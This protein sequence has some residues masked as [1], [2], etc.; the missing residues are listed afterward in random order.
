MTFGRWHRGS[1]SISSDPKDTDLQIVIDFLASSY[2][3]KHLPRAKIVQSFDNCLVY[4]LLDHDIDRQVGFARVVSDHHRFAYLGDVF[5]LE[6]H[7]GQGLGAWL[8]KTV[9]NDPRL[10]NVGHWVLATTN[11]QPFYRKLG[12]EEAEPG[13]YMVRKD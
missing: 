3:A 2:W 13:R 9:I 1:F 8:I 6:R 12:F 5:V 4:N 7:R 10:A 11:A